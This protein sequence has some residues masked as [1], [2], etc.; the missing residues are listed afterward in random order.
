MEKVFSQKLNNWITEWYN[1]HKEIFVFVDEDDFNASDIKA[2]FEGHKLRWEKTGKIH[3]WTGASERT[4]FGSET[5]NHYFRCWHDYVHITNNLG[6]SEIEEVMTCEIQVSQ[7]PSDWSFERDLIRCEVTGQVLYF[8]HNGE[9][10]EDQVKFTE[11]YLKDPSVA[12]MGKKVREILSDFGREVMVRDLT[13]AI[14]KNEG[15]VL[16]DGMRRSIPS[17]QKSGTDTQ[18]HAYAKQLAEKICKDK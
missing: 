13:D 14:L 5:V 11:Q 9:F 16:I 18:R 7:L 1:K 12:V 3:I 17:G 4:I 2:T 10:A 6:Y 15:V 8:F